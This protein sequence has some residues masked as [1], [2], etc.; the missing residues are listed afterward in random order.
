MAN[1]LR[2]V[3]ALHNHQP[4]GN[5]DGTIE[6]AYMDSYLPFL[7]LFE[8]YDSL[9]IALHTSGS[10]MDWLADRHPE[11]L[12]KLAQLTA[13]NRIEI[14]G[15]PYYEPIL[16]M[17]PSRDRIGQIQRYTRFLESRFQTRV[18]GMWMPERIWEQSYIRDLAASGMEY[19]LVD[20]FHFKKAGLQEQELYGRFLSEDDGSLL[21][22]FPGSEPLRYYIPFHD[23][24][25][26]IQYCRKIYEQNPQ[27]IV[28]FGDDGEKFGT[29]PET[30]KHVYDD[31]WLDRFFGAILDNSDWLE[32]TTLSDCVDQ[33]RPLGK[34]YLPDCSYREMTEWSLPV[35]RQH[36]LDDAKKTIRDRLDPESQAKVNEFLKGGFWRNFKVRYPETNEMYARM[37]Q[38]SKR[39]EKTRQIGVQNQSEKA[40][41]LLA[42]AEKELYQGQCNCSYWHGAFGGCYLPHLRNAVYRN[43][44][45]AENRLNEWEQTLYTEYTDGSSRSDFTEENW[46]NKANGPSGAN[47]AATP[48]FNDS[49]NSVKE[50]SDIGNTADNT[51][52]NTAENTAKNTAKNTGDKTTEPG[53][54]KSQQWVEAQ[55][56]DFNFD[57]QTE[58]C[59]NNDKLALYIEPDRGGRIYEMDVRTICH[60]LL[61]TLS[62]RKEFY[63]SKVAAGPNRDGEDCA[64]IHDRV[65]FK[66][67]GLDKKLVYDSYE[68]K[69]LIDLFFDP[70]TTL[71]QIVEGRPVQRGD[72]VDAPYQA[73]VRRNPG[74]V[75][76]K[77]EREGAAMGRNIKIT[78]GI[79]LN[80]GDDM[81]EIAYLLENVPLD[82]PLRFAVELN[83]A[84]IPA[85]CEDRFFYDNSCEKL[86]D[87]GTVQNL[88]PRDFLGLTDQWFGLDIQLII[89]Q[90]TGFWTYPIQ[91]VSNS[92]GG[93]E[94][95]HQSVAVV[96]NWIIQPDEQG[97]WSFVMRMKIKS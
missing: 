29:W 32:M 68:R 44:I 52:D 39:L 1:R 3:L 74:R 30:K 2:F 69:S 46:G 38:V 33:V 43:L 24:Q 73:V 85:G 9:R 86:A 83:F 42:Q 95:V 62:R 93:F 27:G 16:A 20:D 25:D 17:L 22:I 19:T 37:I 56:E 90:P 96:P 28:V 18:R 5:F 84:G 41:E 76:V 50:G 54:L 23:P 53:S 75:Q 82:E 64:S 78:K 13:A 81:I 59:L 94:L 66:Q 15:G 21:S 71:E 55:I 91:T 35:D 92:E 26:T 80:A 48:A 79:T 67:E 57:A 11:Y 51:A 7:E 70:N 6:Q 63:H 47:D 72:F 65:V 97:K 14:L 8:R 31:G 4:I 49:V 12:D 58:I 60:N 61:A 87:T 36:D 89:N 77:M 88:T 10:L 45:Q 34:I 40:V